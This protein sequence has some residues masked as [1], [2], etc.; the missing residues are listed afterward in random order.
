LD[1]NTKYQVK[2][3]H[4]DKEGQIFRL[5]VFVRQGWGCPVLAVFHQ[6]LCQMINKSRRLPAGAIRSGFRLGLGCGGR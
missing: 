4:F 2:P 1:I 6:N 5:L 3:D